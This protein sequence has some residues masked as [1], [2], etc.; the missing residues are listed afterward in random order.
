MVLYLLFPHAEL[1][2]F[3]PSRGRFHPSRCPLVSPP[4]PR[5][6]RSCRYH[7]RVSPVSPVSCLYRHALES[8]FGFLS[9]PRTAGLTCCSQITQLALSTAA[10]VTSEHMAAAASASAAA[11]WPE[12]LLRAAIAVVPLHCAHLARSLHSLSLWSRGRDIVLCPPLISSTST[13]SRPSLASTSTDSLW[14]D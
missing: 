8:V 14:R 3:A 9:S 12:L 10:E 5:C 11:T 13:R 6:G 1:L 7:Q 4:H 2:V